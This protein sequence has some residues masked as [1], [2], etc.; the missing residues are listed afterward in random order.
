MTSQQKKISDIVGEY[1]EVFEEEYQLF[2]GAMIGKRDLQKNDLATTGLEGTIEQ[3]AY[4]IPLTLSEM[5]NDMLNEEE[6]AYLKSRDGA[7]WF[8][9]TFKQFSPAKNI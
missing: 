3:L 4:E 8:G 9:R 5:F 7:L 2:C 1:Q 6:K